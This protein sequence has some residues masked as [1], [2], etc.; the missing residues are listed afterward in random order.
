MIESVQRLKTWV[1][2]LES[3]I[4]GRWRKGSVF[5]WSQA[6][7]I[8]VRGRSQGRRQWCIGTAVGPITGHTGTSF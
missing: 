6:K 2:E 7:L 4:D 1:T 3:M 5:R 8:P